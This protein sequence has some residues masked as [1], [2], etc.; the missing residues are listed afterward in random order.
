MPDRPIP[1]R[2]LT[3][4]PPKRQEPGVYPGQSAPEIPNRPGTEQEMPTR[5]GR[6]GRDIPRYP[7]NPSHEEPLRPGRVEQPE[8][9][10]VPMPPRQEPPP[11]LGRVGPND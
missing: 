1:P 2:P 11:T 6:P 10:G 3:T 5:R 7:E 9:P 4:D 8:V